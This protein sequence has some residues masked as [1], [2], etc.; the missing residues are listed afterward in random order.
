LTNSAFEKEMNDSILLRLKDMCASDGIEAYVDKLLIFLTGT[1]IFFNPFPHTTAIKEICIYLPAAIVLT[2]ILLRKKKMFFD[3]PLTLPF[4]LYALWAFAS[5][6]WSID[7]KNSFHDFYAH[8]L[9]LMFIYYMVINYFDSEKRIVAVGWIIII[10][11]A[12]FAI[13]GEINY[14]VLAGK[15]LSA[16]LIP[17][18]GS[19]I[20]SSAIINIFGFFL[21]LFYLTREKRRFFQII[22]FI[23]LVGT[24]SAVILSYSRAALLGLVVASVVLLFLISKYDKKKFIAV[25]ILIAVAVGILY[26]TSAQMRRLKPENLMK[27]FRLGIYY[28]SFEIVKDYPIAGVGFGMKTFEKYLWQEYNP[29][30]PKKW[31]RKDPAQ[32]PHSFFFSI[33]VRLGIVGIAIFGFIIFRA[34]QISRLILRCD[35]EDIRMWGSYLSASFIGMLIAGLFGS[36]LHGAAAFNFY[37]VLAMMTVFWRLTRQQRDDGRP[38]EVKT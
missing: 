23:C 18:D 25:S 33:L 10:S 24:F 14:Y 4:A 34:F 32:T 6:F 28:T 15:L 29:K 1:F 12:I 35:K 19:P 11:T 5:L 17:I 16:R 38:E 22:L 37:I 7:I 13:K 2:M 30:V 8:L 9:K 3:S 27:N 36:I 20:N 21:S 26:G 31:Q